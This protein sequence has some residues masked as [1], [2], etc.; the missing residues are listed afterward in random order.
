ML[1]A[2]GFEPEVMAHPDIMDHAA[3]I[4]EA[5]DTAHQPRR[6]L[7]ETVVIGGGDLLAMRGHQHVA[8]FE[9]GVLPF[10]FDT[11]HLGPAVDA[12]GQLRRAALDIAFGHQT[13]EHPVDI[14]RV[15][16]FARQAVAGLE[17]REGQL[18]LRIGG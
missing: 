11:R 8:D 16:R 10:A 9:R 17:R 4:A 7:V 12:R 13:D 14:G 6:R 1:A 15:D 3:T 2:Q 18:D 5:L